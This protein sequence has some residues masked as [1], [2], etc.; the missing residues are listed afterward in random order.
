MEGDK[1][2]ITAIIIALHHNEFAQPSRTAQYQKYFQPHIA[3]CTGIDIVQNERIPQPAIL[4]FRDHDKTIDAPTVMYADIEAILEH[5]PAK[6]GVNTQHTHKHTPCALGCMIMSRIPNNRYHGKYVEFV[7]PDCMTQFIDYAEEVLFQVYSWAENFETRCIAQRTPLEQRSFDLE[8]RCYQCKMPFTRKDG[9]S[10]D[11]H[12]DHDHITGL[13]R[14]AACARCNLKIRLSRLTLPIY[15]HNYRGYDNHHI[16]HAFA[17]R[18]YWEC[19]PIAQNMEKFMSMTCKFQVGFNAKGNKLNARIYFRDSLQI[20]PEGL[21][22]LVNNVG[23]SELHETLKMHN[24]YGISKE[25][26]LAKGIFPYSFFD[27][28]DKMK[29]DSLPPIEDFYDTLSD[30][31]ISQADFDRACRAWQEF[32]CDTMQDYM[33]RYLE[34]DVRQLT[35]VFEYGRGISRRDDGLDLAHY[36]TISQLSMA[37]ALKC[38]IKPIGLCPT[39]EMYRLFEKSIRGGISFTNIHYVEATDDVKIM[40]IDANNLYGGAL[41]QKLPRGEFI[42]FYGADSI[43]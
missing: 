26:I 31:D 16:V 13:Y 5:L 9:K 38:Q 32:Q 19:E 20:L 27:S 8:H 7:G 12:F 23:E 6:D 18:K 21:A 37:S 42:E 41:R 35:D 3:K 43:D 15:F 28:F 2:F 4:V 30:R 1:C 29:Y 36:L 33:L 14:G 10:R 40:Y 25:L 34:M 22:A 11:K 24:I 17:G 39:P